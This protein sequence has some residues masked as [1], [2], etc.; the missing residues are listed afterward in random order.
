MFYE[1]ELFRIS[2]TRKQCWKCLFTK[3]GNI[4]IRYYVEK[5]C[6]PNQP[7]E[8]QFYLVY[9]RDIPRFHCWLKD[10]EENEFD[11]GIDLLS[12]LAD[13]LEG[14]SDTSNEETLPIASWSFRSEEVDVDKIIKEAKEVR[15]HL[16]EIERSGNRVVICSPEYAQRVKR[17]K[18]IDFWLARLDY[19]DRFPRFLED[20]KRW[21]KDYSSEHPDGFH[22]I[23]GVNGRTASDLHKMILESERKEAEERTYVRC[24]S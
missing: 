16:V 23:G 19:R 21:V 24:Y 14:S 8:D 3:R 1:K 18:G 4:V 15:A 10:H 17:A 6:C 22:L 2:K 12:A 7:E 20:S 5:S 13:Y 9:R 11:N